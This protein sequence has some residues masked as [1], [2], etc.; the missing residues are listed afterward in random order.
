MVPELNGGGNGVVKALAEV[1]DVIAEAT[2][3]RR[4]GADAALRDLVR[5]ARNLHER[6]VEI[7]RANEPQSSERLFGVRETIDLWISELEAAVNGSPANGP[8]GQ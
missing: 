1:I 2:Q 6:L 7:L 4:L 3:A 8:K 5:R